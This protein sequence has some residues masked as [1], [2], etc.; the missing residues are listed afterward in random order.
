MYET[1]LATTTRCVHERLDTSAAERGYRDIPLLNV[2]IYPKWRIRAL[3]KRLTVAESTNDVP[4]EHRPDQ[5][6]RC[7]LINQLQ[8]RYSIGQIHL[9]LSEIADILCAT[10][11]SESDSTGLR[12]RADRRVELGEKTITV[13]IVCRKCEAA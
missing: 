5:I 13:W 6:Q 1:A 11:N 7:V 4:R 9:R 3:R 8:A 10:E 12:P 2:E